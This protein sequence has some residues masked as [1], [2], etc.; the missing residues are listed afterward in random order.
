M[1]EIRPRKKLS[2]LKRT[3]QNIKRRLRNKAVASKIKTLV[4]KVLVALDAKD[5][6]LTDKSFKDAAKAI[7]S[8][9]TKGVLHR[10]T[11]SRKISRLAKLIN[12]TSKAATA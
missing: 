8:A 5:K 4:K 10:N 11:A 7:S 9:G 3:R 12:R 1:A 6:D 2:V